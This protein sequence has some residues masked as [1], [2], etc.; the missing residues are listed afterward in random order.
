MKKKLIAIFGEAEKGLFKTP[1]L[2]KSLW[3]LSNTFGNPPKSSLAIPFAIQS[4]FYENHLL[5]FRVKEEGFS[6]EEYIE[7]IEILGSFTNDIP[8]TA[9][10]M[11]GVGDNSIIEKTMLICRKK[12]SIFITSFGDL[13]DYFSDR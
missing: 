7:G 9:I 8:I 10:Y 1:V 12:G 3:E 5:F 6:F 13:Y 11:P 4:L 2:I